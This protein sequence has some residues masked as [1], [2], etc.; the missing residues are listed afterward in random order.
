MVRL[1]QRPAP[2]DQRPLDRSWDQPC[3]DKHTM[4]LYHLISFNVCLQVPVGRHP[5]CGP[6]LARAEQ[7]G[8]PIRTL[9]LRRGSLVGSFGLAV[10]RH[11]QSG[12][13]SIQPLDGIVPLLVELI[14]RGIDF[15]LR[16][17]LLLRSAGHQVTNIRLGS[18]L[19]TSSDILQSRGL[20]AKSTRPTQ[21]SSSGA[22]VTGGGALHTSGSGQMTSANIPH[23][24]RGTQYPGSA[25]LYSGPILESSV[26]GV[27]DTGCAQRSGHVANAPD[28]FCLSNATLDAVARAAECASRPSRIRDAQLCLL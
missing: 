14:H 3:I 19:L 1:S 16:L 11:A 27:I 22:S 21:H 26:G 6:N 15:V 7:N 17:R 12:Q 2:S 28:T 10:R 23:R 18:V 5:H 13:P 24:A 20:V 8:C 9:I 4:V 25:R